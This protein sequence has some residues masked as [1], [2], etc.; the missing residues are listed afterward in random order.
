M[1][2][3]N[4]TGHLHSHKLFM[5][6]LRGGEAVTIEFQPTAINPCGKELPVQLAKLN[7]TSFCDL[8]DLVWSQPMRLKLPWE[9]DEFAVIEEHQV[10]SLESLILNV[11]VMPIFFLCLLKFLMEASDE[12]VFI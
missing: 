4:Y 11:S 8:L 9:L 7:G 1:P 6:G 5:L 12:S 3:F 2:P 10:S